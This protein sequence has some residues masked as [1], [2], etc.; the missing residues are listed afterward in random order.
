[1]VRWP[2]WLSA[3]SEHVVLILSGGLDS[4]VLAYRL[5]AAGARLTMLSFDYGQRTGVSWTT[6]AARR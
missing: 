4:T 6:P 2:S 5:R 3:M 1:L